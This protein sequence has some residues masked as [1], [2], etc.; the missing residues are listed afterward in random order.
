VLSWAET[1]SVHF[2]MESSENPFKTL[3]FQPKSREKEALPSRKVEN[4]ST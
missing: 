4:S 3:H 1:L 2:D